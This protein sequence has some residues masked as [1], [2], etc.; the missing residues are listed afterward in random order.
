MVSLEQP[1]RDVEFKPNDEQ[2]QAI[3]YTD[4]PPYLPAGPG[5]GR[6]RV[7]L[8]RTLNLIVFNDI[9]AGHR[10]GN[11]NGARRHYRGKEQTGRRRPVRRQTA[12][13]KGC[14]LGLGMTLATDEI[15]P[16]LWKG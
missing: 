4:G 5:S 3:C 6:T 8:W 9:G 15:L 2:K 7:L 11:R 16:L 10:Q 14:D 12:F 1:W 13:R